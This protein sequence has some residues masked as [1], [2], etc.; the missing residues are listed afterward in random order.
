MVLGYFVAAIK[1]KHSLS[2]PLKGFTLTT[3]GSFTFAVLSL[4]LEFAFER[5]LASAEDS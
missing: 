2:P 5:D 1:K 4:G 3:D